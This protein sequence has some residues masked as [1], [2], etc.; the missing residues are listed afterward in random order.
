[1]KRLRIYLDTT[2]W[3]FAFSNQQPDYKKATLE[4]YQKVRWGLYDVYYSDVVADELAAAPTGRHE[5]VHRLLEEIAPQR[6]MPHA[7]IDRLGALYLKRKVL[8]AKSVADAMH[9]AYATYYGVDALLSWNF[10]HLANMNRRVRVNAVN[11]GEGYHLPLV[12]ATP[13]E[14]LGDEDED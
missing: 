3:N 1:M 2:I 5:Q 9:V 6:L 7:E 11:M 14:V 10:K 4:F 12:L 8:P 13:L